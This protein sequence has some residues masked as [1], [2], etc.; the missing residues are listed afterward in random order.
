M[1]CTSDTSIFSRDVVSSISSGYGC[2]AHDHHH[3]TEVIRKP[4]TN[5]QIKQRQQ[6]QQKA[7]MTDVSYGIISTFSTGFNMFQPFLFVHLCSLGSPVC[8]SGFAAEPRCRALGLEPHTKKGVHLLRPKELQKG[9][10]AVIHDAS[11]VWCHG[12][13]WC[14]QSLFLDGPNINQ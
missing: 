13:P 11:P 14:S 4:D 5:S 1:A 9:C 3:E 8:Q 2:D 6:N 7:C 10:D 12:M